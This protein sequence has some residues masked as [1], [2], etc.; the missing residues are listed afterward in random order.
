MCCLIVSS[1]IWVKSCL[2]AL[3]RSPCIEIVKRSPSYSSPTYLFVIFSS[4]SLL[5]LTPHSLSIYFTFFL[6][7]Y[8]FL[9]FSP[10]LSSPL[11]LFNFNLSPSFHF[12]VP[13]FRPSLGQSW[14]PAKDGLVRRPWRAQARPA[15][16]VLNQWVSSFNFLPYSFDFRV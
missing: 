1:A 5:Y 3:T 9:L 16:W 14:F 7:L 6:A 2:Y 12:L 11:F 8:H 13:L 4:S 15:N 10:S